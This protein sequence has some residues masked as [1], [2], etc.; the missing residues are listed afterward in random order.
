M[1]AFGQLLAM[2][3][4]TKGIEAQVGG[5]S[6]WGTS[7]LLPPCIALHSFTGK[8]DMV[9]S[10]LAL[11]AK[12]GMHIYFS[13]SVVINIPFSNI[14]SNQLEAASARLK[15]LAAS[16]REVPIKRLL[17]ESDLAS[18]YDVDRNMLKVAA[19]VAAAKAMPIDLILRSSIEN[20]EQFFGLG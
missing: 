8:V 5:R 20:A 18:P 7:T 14:C 19:V 15:R 13:F 11:E 17:L 1:Q 12:T 9:R 6:D 10:L 16:I 3:G 4:N 2:L